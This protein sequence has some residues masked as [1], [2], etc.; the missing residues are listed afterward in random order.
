MSFTAFISAYQIGS[1]YINSKSAEK[2]R[3]RAARL[4]AM[5]QAK[6]DGKRADNLKI[7][8]QDVFERSKE[9]E[10]L[11]YNRVSKMIGTQ[12][13]VLAAKGIKVDSGIG[14]R[15]QEETRRYGREDASTIRENAQREVWG[16][17]NEIEQL[18]ERAQNAIETGNIQASNIEEAGRRERESLILGGISEF[19]RFGINDERR[20]QQ[21][22]KI[23]RSY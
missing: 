22:L 17:D 10:Q 9:Q 23:T 18:Y 6:Q 15:I 20:E 16:M 2:A 12:R 3:V 5:F 11:I 7:E 8:K 4:Q 19:A 13:A 1:G 21:R 14:Q